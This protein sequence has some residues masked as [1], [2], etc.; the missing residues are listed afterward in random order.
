MPMPS[1]PITSRYG[2]RMDPFLHRL[3]MH[4]GIDFKAPTGSPARATAPG[5]VTIAAYTKGYGNMVEIDHGGGVSTRYAH[6]SRLMV[7]PGAYVDTGTIVGQT[8]STGRS[9]GPHL[10]YEIRVNN[11]AIDPMAY[12]KAGTELT[13]LL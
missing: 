3:A 8:G 2:A 6:L 4:A 10:H 13:P 12:I 9:T 7:K 5:K 11:K 1:A